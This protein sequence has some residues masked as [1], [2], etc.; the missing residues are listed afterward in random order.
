M[1]DRADKRSADRDR[2]VAGP[3]RGIVW[4]ASKTYPASAMYQ[5]TPPGGSYIGGHFRLRAK[6]ID[7]TRARQVRGRDPL[8]LSHL[9]FARKVSS[10]GLCL[11][12]TR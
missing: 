6:P 5:H 4:K 1:S 10:A 9:R 3:P 7:E 2:A 8:H 11:G 12:I